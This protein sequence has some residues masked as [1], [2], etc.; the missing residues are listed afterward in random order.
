MLKCP[1]VLLTGLSKDG[2]ARSN[3]PMTRWD[4]D[5]LQT[6][7][8]GV[9]H[10]ARP[11][12]DPLRQGPEELN[13]MLKIRLPGGWGGTMHDWEV[14]ASARVGGRTWMRWKIHSANPHP[15]HHTTQ[16]VSRPSVRQQ[17]TA[18]SAAS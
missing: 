7:Q 12:N 3:L 17:T 18:F 2:Y 8:C 1:P 9:D 14:L 11:G 5:N 15:K 4:L 10:I 16:I 6:E 13:K